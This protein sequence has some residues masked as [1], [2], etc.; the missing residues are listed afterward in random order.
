[1]TTEQE[2][3]E[4]LK[5]GG[6]EIKEEKEEQKQEEQEEEIIQETVTE[7]SARTGGWKPKEEFDGDP[8]EW[9]TAKEFL[10]RGE[11]FNKIHNQN[12]KI[13]QLE[14]ALETMAGHHKRVFESAYN[15]AKSDLKRQRAQAIDDGD[16]QAVE[17]IE[18]HMEQLETKYQEE[19]KHLDIKIQEEEETQQKS[20]QQSNT[21]NPDFVR[22]VADNNWFYTDTP[23]R[24]FAEQV[25]VQHAVSNPGISNAEIYDYVTQQVKEHF[26][27]K[28]GSKK[29]KPSIRKATVVEG[30]T[31]T[32]R[33]RTPQNNSNAELTFEEEHVARTL[34]ERGLYKDKAEYVAELKKAGLK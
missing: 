22:W 27:E 6:I 12:R 11:Y 29:E 30:D 2:V 1:M 33:T 28:F 23:L 14:N 21:P 17:V 9:V 24:A 10:R 26:P 18:D 32:R 31:N 19:S 8:E 20:Q 16:G 15:K 4:K 13:K 3:Q 34:I 7:K 25:G 5:A